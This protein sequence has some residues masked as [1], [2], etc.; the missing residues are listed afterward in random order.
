MA[1]QVKHTKLFAVMAS[2]DMTLLRVVMRLKT[3]NTDAIIA[4]IAGELREHGIELLNSTAFLAPL[5][6]GAGVLTRRAAD[7]RRSSRIS[8]SGIAWRTSSPASTSG[9]RSR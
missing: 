6:A 3:R 5:L 8:S 9:R 7:R 4:G 2:A 1:G